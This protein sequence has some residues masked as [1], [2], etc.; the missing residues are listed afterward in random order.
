[1]R[2]LSRAIR[3]LIP[4]LAAALPLAASAQ[5]FPSA[6][7]RVIVPYP[8]GG[9]LDAVIRPVAEKF[10][11]ATGQTMV[12][13]NLG[14][15]GGLIA[16]AKVA[17]S[18]PDGYTLLL[19]SNGQVSLAPLLYSS[20]SYDAEKDLVP[21]IHLTDQ[22]AVLYANSKTP[23]KTV[24]DVIAAAKAAP[25]T[26]A[27]ASTGAGGISHLAIELLG[28][29]TGAKFN[30]IP[31]K[32]AVPALQDVAGGQVPLVFTFVGSAKALTA[33][34]HVRPLA[35]AS[36]KRLASLPDVPTF[37]EAGIPNFQVSSWMGLMAPRD[38]PPAV[39]QRMATVAGEIMKQP[40]FQKKMA[41]ISMEIR[42]GTP[43]NFKSAI[44]ADTVKWSNL[45]KTVNLKQ[46]Q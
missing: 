38:T 43:A 22:V 19:A 17:Q 6:P 14:G 26:V 39:I 35:V 28:Q 7:V 11:Q 9:S 25:G 20:M 16:G 29:A 45:A 41:D 30:H 27:F 23:Y 37:A 32:G 12:V 34:G 1:M 40:D 2:L 10:Q 24:A 36:D 31:Y 18:K 3:F 42:G 13:E 4:A 46:Q 8:A 5:D 15:A 33:S 44:Q 21:I